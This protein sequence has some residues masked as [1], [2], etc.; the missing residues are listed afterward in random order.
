[1]NKTFLQAE[2][3]FQVEISVE[4]LG[5]VDVHA[6]CVQTE[7]IGL[8]GGIYCSKLR[9]LHINIAEPCRSIT[10]STTDLQCEMDPVS[11]MEGKNH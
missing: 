2:P 8:L 5:V 3:P 9:K 1:M 4:A 11:Q 6:H 7:V 10:D